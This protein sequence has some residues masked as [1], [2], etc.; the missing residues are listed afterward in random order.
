MQPCLGGWWPARGFPRRAPRRLR[1]PQEPAPRAAQEEH[2]GGH[3]TRGPSPFANPPRPSGRTSP[4]LSLADQ[5]RLTDPGAREILGLRRATATAPCR[6]PPRP[7]PPAS[8]SHG[9][10]LTGQLLW[11]ASEEAAR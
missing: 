4:C 7:G 1:G 11:S 6:D 2:H 9:L 10:G 5:H 8:G 3:R